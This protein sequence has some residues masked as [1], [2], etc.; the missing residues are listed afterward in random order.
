MLIA[1]LLLVWLHIILNLLSWLNIDDPL[2]PLSLN[3][4]F[5]LN[6]IIPQIQN[7]REIKVKTGSTQWL[8]KTKEG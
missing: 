4:F 1:N 8:T 3:I 2:V 6:L 7:W 5:R